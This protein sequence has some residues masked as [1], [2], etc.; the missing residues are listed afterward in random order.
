MIV[1]SHPQQLACT[2]VGGWLKLPMAAL[3]QLKL[4]G[5]FSAM[6]PGDGQK[7]VASHLFLTSKQT[8]VQAT[9]YT[10]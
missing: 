4:Q 7:E 3:A 5:A 2:V 9:L 6:A 8:Y 1:T 10:P